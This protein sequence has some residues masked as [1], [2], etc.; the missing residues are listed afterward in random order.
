MRLIRGKI[1]ARHIL[2][3]MYEDIRRG[4]ITPGLAVVWVGNDQASKI[5]IGLK[6]K[7]A[8]KIGIKFYLYRFSKNNKTSD[9]IKK[10]KLLNK[11]KDIHGII[12][13]LPLPKKFNTQKII[14]A[15]DPRKDADGF[16]PQNIKLFF[17]KREF[18]WPVFPRAIVKMIESVPV[19]KKIKNAVILSRSELFGKVMAEG[20]SRKK[21]KTKMAIIK[22]K[23]GVRGFNG[24][25][26]KVG[27]VG[28]DLKKSDLIISATG[29]PQF[30]KGEM[31]KKG[32]VIIDGGITKVGK[33]VSGD[34]DLESV[35]KI[36]GA[37]SPVPGGVGPVT[38]ATLIE[39]VIQLAERSK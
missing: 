6:K 36:A 26:E 29:I 20:L 30:I 17:A 12:V 3:K 13:Q 32:A 37:V 33:K 38:V 2:A 34:V 23:L 24:T 16:H 14:D 28:N 18:I 9:V 1:I 10:I 4:K 25:I 5:Y 31:I 19:N 15:I 35:K 22:G 27:I 21:I 11:N 8:K 39:N 7:A